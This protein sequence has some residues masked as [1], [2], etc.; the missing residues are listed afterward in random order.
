MTA[1]HKLTIF[2]GCIV[3]SLGLDNLEIIPRA[4]IGVGQDGTIL[5]VDRTSSTPLEAA[6]N[7]GV[8]QEDLTVVKL[9]NRSSFF[10]PGFFDT[11]IVS[12]QHWFVIMVCYHGLLS[13]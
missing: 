13:I 11:H 3:H 4:N 9:P 6:R 2:S 5:F 12:Y 10:F 8:S 7:F 1:S